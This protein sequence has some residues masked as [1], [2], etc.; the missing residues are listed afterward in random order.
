VIDVDPAL[1]LPEPI[2]FAVGAEQYALDP[3]V[4]R[5][6][7]AL[8]L[9]P[10]I[11]EPTTDPTPALAR[12]LV[13][14]KP[15]QSGRVEIAGEDIYSTEYGRRQRLRGRI[16]FVHAYGGLLANRT[17]RENL[18]LPVSVHR[19]L[20]VAEEAEIVEASLARFHLES[21][22]DLRPH[23]M[24][25]ATRWRVCVARALILSPLWVVFEGLGDWE[26]DRGRGI[27]WTQL[28]A[29]WQGGAS[30]M[31]ICLPR[32]NPEFE[33]WFEE[34]GGRLVRYQ[35]VIGDRGAAP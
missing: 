15:P 2:L 33:A 25:G 8:A 23:Q 26:M 5:R 24:D 30:A 11:A 16:G 35:R 19:R 12:I 1:C 3:L 31:G 32:Q 4:V 18:G 14:L 27:S 6:G 34:R 17:V 13:S 7:E 28:I 10:S 29:S 9:V 22:A 21:V 20:P